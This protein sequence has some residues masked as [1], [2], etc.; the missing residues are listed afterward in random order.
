M[1]AALV[2]GDDAGAKATVT[3]L[4][5]DLGC[6]DGSVVDLGGIQSARG[7]EPYF[8]MFAALMQSLRTPRATFARGSGT[9]GVTLAAATWGCETAGVPTPNVGERD[10]RAPVV[11]GRLRLLSA[12]PEDTLDGREGVSR[13]AN[14][15]DLGVGGVPV[16]EV[17]YP[18]KPLRRLRCGGKIRVLAVDESADGDP[19]VRS[20]GHLTNQ[21]GV[22]VGVVGQ[23]KVTGLQS[24]CPQAFLYCGGLFGML[25]ETQDAPAVGLTG[26]F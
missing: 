17:Q 22:A 5:A 7:P 12:S 9:L 11:L 19:V 16:H 14:Q 4:L 3:G 23:R 25:P 18:V 26:R 2:S 13:I 21:L 6:A 20:L 8:V 24:C 1:M 10:D 15:D